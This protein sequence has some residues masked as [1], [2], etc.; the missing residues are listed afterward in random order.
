MKTQF[1]IKETSMTHKAILAV[2]LGTMML[3]ACSSLEER[4]RTNGDFE[5]VEANLQEVYKV[6]ANLDKP[7]INNEYAIPELGPNAPKDLIGTKISVI[8]PSLVL[9]LVTGSH[10]EEGYKEATVWFDQIDDSQPLDATIWNSLR[11]FLDAQGIGIVN[12]DREQQVLVTDWMIIEDDEDN[13][14]FNWTTTER[15]I[16]RRFEFKLDIKPHGRSA[17]LKTQLRDYLETRGEE[18]IA[19]IDRDSE[20][21]NEVDILNQVISH[22]EKQVR[23][24]DIKRIEQIRSGFAM[25]LGFNKDGDPAYLVDGQYD[26]VWPRLLLVLRNLGFN[27]KDLDKS[28]GLLFVSYGGE[29]SGWWGSLFSSDDD[30]LNLDEDDYRIQV[31]K[32]GPKTSITLMDNESNPFEVTK[33]TE[34]FPPFS[35]TMTTD[36]LDI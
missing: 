11:S 3:T 7:E 22:Y 33:V 36:N 8:S 23:L 10:V 28:N 4:Q 32:A 6:P 5:Y 17:A 1:G 24:A 14:W 15:S 21:R 25:E 2:C 18:V 12:F 30:V 34:L 9:P 27:V 31:L 35:K 26:L 29:S 13:G 16:G 20:R 19:D